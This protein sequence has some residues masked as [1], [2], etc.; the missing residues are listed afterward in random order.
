MKH[1]RRDE[2]LQALAVLDRMIERTNTTNIRL[3]RAAVREKV[4]DLTG[5]LLDLSTGN[6]T[7]NQILMKARLQAKLGFSEESVITLNSLLKRI[8]KQE[9]SHWA[10]IAMGVAG[11]RFD[12]KL[13][14][15]DPENMIKTPGLDERMKGGAVEHLIALGEFEACK[16]LL[17]NDNAESFSLLAILKEVLFPCRLFLHFG[18]RVLLFSADDNI[19]FVYRY[20]CHQSDCFMIQRLESISVR[21]FKALFHHKGANHVYLL[22]Q[23]DI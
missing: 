11:R 16:K 1:F 9:Y 6:G 19:G 22:H 17:E 3:L 10:T 14:D 21:Y 2:Y 12:L 8:D 23:F 7:S 13:L 15:V 20:F 4:N 5:A 18:R